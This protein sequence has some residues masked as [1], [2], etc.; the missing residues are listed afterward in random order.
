M[1]H[2]R[3]PAY[4]C[5]N[6]EAHAQVCEQGTCSQR[7]EVSDIHSL[8]TS[9]EFGELRVLSVTLHLTHG[10]LAPWSTASPKVT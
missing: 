1:R 7:A 5:G 10:A 8:Q 6:W 9:C 2:L 4:A 3:L